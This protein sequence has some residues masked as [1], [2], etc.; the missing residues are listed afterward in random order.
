MRTY[1]VYSSSPRLEDFVLS[2]NVLLLAMAVKSGT[3]A[4]AG[5]VELSLHAKACLLRD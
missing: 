5:G 1:L 4:A 3:A 2:D